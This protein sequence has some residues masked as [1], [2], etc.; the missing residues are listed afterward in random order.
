[1]TDMKLLHQDSNESVHSA[2]SAFE[3]DMFGSAQDDKK[4]ENASNDTSSFSY[5]FN[6]FR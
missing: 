6:I 4:Q 3:K 1:M 2:L 5:L